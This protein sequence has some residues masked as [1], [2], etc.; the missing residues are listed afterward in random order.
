MFH[1]LL[2]PLIPMGF[3]LIAFKLAGSLLEFVQLTLRF[4][5][6]CSHTQCPV[7]ILTTIM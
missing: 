1:N 7:Q 5:M 6:C 3:A 4:I 2:Q